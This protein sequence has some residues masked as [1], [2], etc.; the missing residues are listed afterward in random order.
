[1]VRALLYIGM[2]R[3]TVDER[4]FEAIRRVRQAQ[5]E[6]PPISLEQFKSLVREQYFMLLLDP[7]TAIEGIPSM[8]PP[9]REA[10]SKAVELIQEISKSSGPLPPEGQERLQQIKSLFGTGTHDPT[11]AASIID[12]NAG[13]S[14]PKAKPA[15]PNPSRSG[16]VKNEGRNK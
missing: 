3:A 4:G 5:K 16:A 10:R 12:M 15:L 14:Q 7:T 8:L 6:L 2:T 1:M 11:S 9:A 13:R